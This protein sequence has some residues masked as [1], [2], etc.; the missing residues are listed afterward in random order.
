MKPLEHF[1]RRDA[2]GEVGNIG[3]GRAAAALEF[4]TGTTGALSPPRVGSGVRPLGAIEIALKLE[5]DLPGE[6]ILNLNTHAVHGLLKRMCGSTPESLTGLAE[7]D[8]SAL[9]ELANVIGCAYLTALSEFTGLAF[10]PLVPDLRLGGRVQE[11]SD[12]LWIASKLRGS[13]NFEADLVLMLEPTSSHRI[14]NAIHRV[15]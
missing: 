15:A 10:H 5:G 12:G 13:E 4:F 14:L 7:G 9:C 2:L 1:L 6:I 3:A 11:Q 8:T